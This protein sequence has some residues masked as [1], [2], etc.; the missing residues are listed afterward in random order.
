MSKVTGAPSDPKT[1][2]KSTPLEHFGNGMCF[3][4]AELAGKFLCY[5]LGMFLVELLQLAWA[6]SRKR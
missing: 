2:D 1:G 3:A 4:F 5:R 6:L